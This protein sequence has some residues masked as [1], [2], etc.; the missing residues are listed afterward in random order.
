MRRLRTLVTIC[1]LVAS[2][3]SC[4]HR[5]NLPSEDDGFRTPSAPRIDV[6][7]GSDTEPAGTE[8]S[9]LPAQSASLTQELQVTFLARSEGDRIG[10]FAVALACPEQD[11]PCI[12]PVE[13]LF[14]MPESTLRPS[15][16]Y[17]WSPSGQSI[18]IET[19]HQTAYP[20]LA[21]FSWHGEGR[22]R[23]THSAGGA[24]APA[25]S[26]NGEFVLFTSCSPDACGLAVVELKTGEVLPL[27][28]ILQSSSLE[29]PA[30][31]PDGRS[32][33]FSAFLPDEGRSQL[34][35][36]DRSMEDARQLTH[37][38]NAR[39]PEFSPDG[40][41]IIYLQDTPI[42][43]SFGDHSP[44]LY[45]LDLEPGSSYPLV[46]DD[47]LESLPG[48]W[49]SPGAWSPLGGWIAFVAT[50]FRIDGGE[51]TDLFLIRPGGKHLINVTDT[52]T[53][54]EWSPQWRQSA[55]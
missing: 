1:I 6:E 21:S 55:R 14:D 12:G 24:F 3:T 8:P 2:V 37:G 35:L 4:G 7:S 34:F 11:P 36:S 48:F 38:L 44:Q 41:Q 51:G 27:P 17:S 13:L 49:H 25:F 31:A 32:I 43:D 46:A 47:F 22:K 16:T 52:P 23:L 20:D 39:S 29:T 15:A 19:L 40:S 9:E 50:D 42:P 54:N 28:H 10:L 33:A 53:A 30:W 26:P 18:V 45:L 5:N